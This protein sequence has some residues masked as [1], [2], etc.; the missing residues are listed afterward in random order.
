MKMRTKEKG[1]TSKELKELIALGKESGQ[2]TYQEINEMLPDEML[3]TGEIEDLFSLLSDL[4]IDVVDEYKPKLSTTIETNEVEEVE[5][6]PSA[7]EVK[8]DD[9]VR[10][11]LKEIGKISIVVRDKAADILSS[12][13]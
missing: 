9:S 3:S 5:I 13:P 2:L 7:L 10:M 4:H 12:C 11:Y 6:L 8:T 1:P